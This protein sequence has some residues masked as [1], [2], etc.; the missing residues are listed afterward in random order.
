[1]I[2]TDDELRLFGG[3]RTWLGPQPTPFLCGLTVIK[4]VRYRARKHLLK[5]V[6]L[7]HVNFR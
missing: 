7:P 3:E 6:Q 5:A 1:M 2:V 4:S